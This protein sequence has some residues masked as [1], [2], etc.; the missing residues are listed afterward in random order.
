MS[1]PGVIFGGSEALGFSSDA[2][3]L[4]T[5]VLRLCV[6]RTVIFYYLLILVVWVLTFRCRKVILRLS[7]GTLPLVLR[8]T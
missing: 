8:L 6:Y 5:R 1:L 4:D 2:E 3:Y 7:S